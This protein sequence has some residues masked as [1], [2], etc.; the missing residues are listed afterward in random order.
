[1]NGLTVRRTRRSIVMK[2][3]RKVTRKDSPDSVFP[4]RCVLKVRSRHSEAE[5]SGQDGDDTSELS[6]SDA[7]DDPEA[8][9]HLA[10]FI[11][12]LDAG[13]KRKSPPADVDANETG[14]QKRRA[15][16]ERT[17]AG[18]ENEYSVRLSGT[19][20]S[21]SFACMLKPCD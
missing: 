12:N 18:V 3:L 10:D 2:R 19:I 21:S 16:M 4:Q 17:E 7:E 20:I 9:N 6:A 11:S 15:I 8:A 1:M 14:P 5:Y 13:R